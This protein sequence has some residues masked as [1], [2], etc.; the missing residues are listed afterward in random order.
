MEK[1]N[2]CIKRSDMMAVLE[3]VGIDSQLACEISDKIADVEI[4][5]VIHA[6]WERPQKKQREY[7]C[8][9]CGAGA[10]VSYYYCPYCGA[11]MDGEG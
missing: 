6:H 11:R 5:T 4:D 1:A 3:E 10:Y 8:S 2:E 9:S 7:L